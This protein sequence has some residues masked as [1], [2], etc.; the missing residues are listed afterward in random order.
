M[1]LISTY[2]CRLGFAVDTKA[3][4]LFDFIKHNI[5]QKLAYRVKYIGQIRE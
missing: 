3:T 1:Q 4:Q 5:I 2:W